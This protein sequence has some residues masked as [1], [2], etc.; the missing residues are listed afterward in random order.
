MLFKSYAHSKCSY[1]GKVPKI[2]FENLTKKLI[3]FE[4]FFVGKVP[5]IV[6]FNRVCLENSENQIWK[7]HENQKRVKIKN[8]VLAAS[9]KLYSGQLNLNLRHG[10]C[11]N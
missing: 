4:A 9:R 7:N 6:V 5:K 8:R 1:V 10:F 2:I 3:N 11:R